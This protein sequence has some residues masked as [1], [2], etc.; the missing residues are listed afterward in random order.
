MKTIPSL[1]VAGLA[2]VSLALAADPAKP[3]VSLTAKKQV[4]DSD[5][6]LRARRGSVQQKTIALR[7]E[8]RNTS[9]ETIDGAEITGHALVMRAKD[10]AEKL[11]K[12]PLGTLK[13]PE[14]KPNGKVTLELGKIELHEKEW[15]NRKFE[16]SLDEWQVTC[17]KTGTEIGKAVSSDKYESL[18]KDA[19][20][21]KGSQAGP[22]RKKKRAGQ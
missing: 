2:C 8:I 21:P 6:D 9:T 12:E 1:I 4:L 5:H 15:R 13:V 11:I 10:T 19:V 3:L 7:M 22:G 16:E 20:Q 17:T 18:E 14:L